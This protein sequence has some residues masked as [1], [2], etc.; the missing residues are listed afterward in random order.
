[1]AKWM[2]FRGLT[3][4]SGLGKSFVCTDQVGHAVA[5]LFTAWENA[6]R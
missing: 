1:M 2:S 5:A 3:L 6:A 4:G